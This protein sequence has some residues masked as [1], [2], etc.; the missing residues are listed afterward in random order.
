MICQITLSPLKKVCIVICGGIAFLLLFPSAKTLSY[1][2]S[3][4][5]AATVLAI[6]S[7]FWSAESMTV[8]ESQVE[9]IK[10]MDIDQVPMGLGIIQFCFVAHGALPTMYREMKAP[11]KD[12]SKAMSRA[13]AFAVMFYMTVGFFA[14]YVYGS[15]AQPNFMQ[16]LGRELNLQPIPGK[17]FLYIFATTFFTVNIQ[18]SFPLFALGLITASELRLNIA[19]RGFFIRTLWKFI[20]IAFTTALSV[21]LNNCMA[22]VL[23]LV[24][25][26]CATNTCLLFPMIFTLKLRDTSVRTKVVISFALAYSAYTLIVGT[27]HNVKVI[28]N[29]VM[30]DS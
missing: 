28:V 30:A 19:K 7:L 17:A 29:M 4:G 9:E 27:Y 16:N 21:M 1:F 14:F 3:V 22:P 25:C 5:I 11:H 26:F 18:L 13:F 12:Y 20:F 2:S 15:Q 8:W 24:G 6:G 10:W 23:S